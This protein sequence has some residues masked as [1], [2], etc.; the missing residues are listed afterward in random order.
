MC[1]DVTAL[2]TLTE[3]PIEKQSIL[4]TPF[5]GHHVILVGN[6]YKKYGEKM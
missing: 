1:C 2:S 3:C 6:F 4:Y 5:G